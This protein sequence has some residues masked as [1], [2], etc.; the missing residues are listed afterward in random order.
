METIAG[1]TWRH[2]GHVGGQEETL[3]SPLGT[4]RYFHVNNIHEKITQFW[5]AEKEVQLFCNTSAK[6]VTRGQITNG[7]WVAENTKETTKNQ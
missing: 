4:K 2:E 7:F 5:F 3:F 1:S 6:L